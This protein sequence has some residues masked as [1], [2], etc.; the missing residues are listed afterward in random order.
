MKKIFLRFSLNLNKSIDS[1]ISA[2]IFGPDQV[3][4]LLKEEYISTISEIFNTKRY[5]DGLCICIT[6][7]KC[8]ESASSNVWN[9][10]ERYIQFIKFAICSALYGFVS[11]LYY[12]NKRQKL[13]L[14]YCYNIIL[15]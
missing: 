13:H 10:S 8:Y 6:V 4:L 7:P 1:N 15:R 2:N 14:W 11:H 9:S 3:R 12:V 5:S